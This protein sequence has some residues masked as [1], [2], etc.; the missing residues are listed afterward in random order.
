MWL[1]SRPGSERHDG[2]IVACFLKDPRCPQKKLRKDMD[3][4]D[5]LP[6][7]DTG[8]IETCQR[9]YEM[10]SDL[11]KQGPRLSKKKIVEHS[12]SMDELK[13]EPQISKRW[14]ILRVPS[15]VREVDE[16]AYNP[17]IV[18]IGPLHHHSINPALQAME[19]QKM[20]FLKRLLEQNNLSKSDVEK[21]MGELEART[22][23]CYSEV[24]DDIKSSEFVQMMVLDACFIVE[25]FRLHEN[26]YE[27]IEVEEPMFGTRWMVPNIGRDLLMLENQ[28]PMFVLQKMYLM[29]SSSTS[30]PTTSLNKLALRFFEG[31]RLGRDKMPSEK[32]KIENEYQ[33]LLDLFHSSFFP[34]HDTNPSKFSKE[35]DIERLP[36]KGWVNS[37]TRLDFAG[38]KLKCK[39]RYNHLLD[40][41]FKGKVLKIPTI[42][43]DDGTSPLLRNL[44]AFEQS[45]RYVSAYFTCLA[46][47]YD[48]IIDTQKD[49]NI[50]RNVGI[51]K[52][53][54]GGNNEILD[55]L[56]SLSKEL[57]FDMEDCCMIMPQIDQINYK[58]RSWKAILKMKIWSCLSRLDYLSYVLTYLTIGQTVF[59]ILY[60]YR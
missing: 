57:E 28:L 11:K 37:A 41:E 16:K 10:E 19:A 14:S 33:H 45:N 6:P 35:K 32:L 1:N 22:R 39:L 8:R 46:V 31:L 18:S 12:I 25:L 52:Q 13:I 23:E 7:I 55:L 29:S 21:A 4:E 9:R 58:C 53:V 2:A 43:L 49:V 38:I 51:I 42:Y 48:S 26:I 24:F 17:K 47:F 34:R 56:N 50:L 15:H 5:L 59:T 44:I 27:G 36:G 20:R 3:F 60:N 54:K 30:S 40:M